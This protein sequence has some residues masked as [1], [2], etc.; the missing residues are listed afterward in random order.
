M[1]ATRLKTRARHVREQIEAVRAAWAD[2]ELRHAAWQRVPPQHRHVA[3]AR[4]SGPDTGQSHADGAAPADSAAVTRTLEKIA[5]GEAQAQ[6]AKDALVEAN[7][8]LVVSIAKKYTHRGLS[9]LDLVQEGNIGLMRAVDKFEYRRGYKFSTYATWW[10]RQAVTRAV[11]DRARTIRVPVHMIDQISTLSRASQVLAQEWGREPSPAEL[12]RELGRSVAQVLEAR[13]IAHHAISL[14]TPLG[15]MATTRSGTPFRIG[16]HIRRSTWRARSRRGHGPRRSCRRSR[17][18]SRDSAAAMWDGGWERADP[19]G[20]R[21]GL[22][23]HPRTDSAGGGESSEQAQV[24][25]TPSGTPRVA[26][27]P[28]HQARG[29]RAHD[30]RVRPHDDR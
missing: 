16:R 5:R 4:T 9:F 13:Q 29:A 24:S 1:T 30:G 10:I 6:Q 14:E 19:R 21:A 18:E 22:W 28:S 3:P 27:G 7:L 2:A 11:A 17:P 12:G 25:R 8:R 23:A 20:G 15:R 26:R